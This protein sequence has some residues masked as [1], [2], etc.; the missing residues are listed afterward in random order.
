MSKQR[1]ILSVLLVLA[2][3]VPGVILAQPAAPQVTPQPE[4][5]VGSTLF[6]ENTG[7]WPAAARF[8]VWG[9]PAS[10][11]TTWLADDAIWITL[12]GFAD[13]H[14]HSHANSHPDG[15]AHRAPLVPAADVAT[16]G[17]RSRTVWK[18]TASPDGHGRRPARAG[19]DPD[20]HGRRPA[21]QRVWC[22]ELRG[23][24]A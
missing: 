1:V 15:N 16:I 3:L 18:T 4:P 21:G 6:I 14:G 11:G 12:D 17:L 24:A 13:W 22:A 20:E 2:L 7:Q 8:Q 19:L 10:V 23:S 9:S 5:P